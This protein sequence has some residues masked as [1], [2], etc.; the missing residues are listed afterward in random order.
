VAHKAAEF[1]FVKACDKKTQETVHSKGP[2]ELVFIDPD[3][4]ELH[5]G[6]CLD[7]AAIE[8]AMDAALGKYAGR[9]ISWNLYEAKALESAR[10]AGKLALV[11]FDDGGKEGEALLKGLE[12]RML[13]RLQDRFTFIRVPFRK[14]SDEARLWGVSSAPMLLV[15]DPAGEAGGAHSVVERISG[16]KTPAQLKSLIQKVSRSQEKS[17]R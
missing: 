4:N 11:A 13:A 10:A 9:P 8:K 16:K 6:V 2:G 15:I 3:G 5:R 7:A 17:P 14:E 1:L 12:D